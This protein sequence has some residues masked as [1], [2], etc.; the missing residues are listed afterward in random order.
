MEI[1]YLN[2]TDEVIELK[3]LYVDNVRKEMF[4]QIILFEMA[5]VVIVKV[6]YSFASD[7]TI[8]IG[9]KQVITKRVCRFE[10]EEN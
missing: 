1:K 4:F 3:K 2:E 9:Y 7:P 5:Y 8:K 6:D 10:N